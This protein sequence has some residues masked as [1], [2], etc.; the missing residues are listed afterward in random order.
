M[1]ATDKHTMQHHVLHTT[2][3]TQKLTSILGPPWAL[4]QTLAAEYV[5]DRAG[6]RRGRNVHKPRRHYGTS[7][8]PK[9]N[10]NDF[11]QSARNKPLRIHQIS[12]TLTKLILHMT[13]CNLRA[14]ATPRNALTRANGASEAR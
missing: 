14:A 3:L 10:P 6:A 4:S 5:D 7:A 13:N 9:T 2:E 8:K 11:N 12:E 1:R